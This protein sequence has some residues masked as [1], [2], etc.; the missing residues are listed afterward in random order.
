[1]V[2]TM[3]SKKGKKE[4]MKERDVLTE[5]LITNRNMLLKMARLIFGNDQRKVD[6]FV[7]ECRKDA[8]RV[9]KESKYSFIIEI[10]KSIDNIKNI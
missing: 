1:M 3:E 5:Y 9:M 7:D 8:K 10:M 2:L 6:K 4:K